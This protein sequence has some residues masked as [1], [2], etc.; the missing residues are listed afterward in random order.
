[1]LHET[2]GYK[3]VYVID[4]MPYQIGTI[5]TKSDKILVYE[6]YLITLLQKLHDLGFFYKALSYTYWFQYK[7]WSLVLVWYKSLGIL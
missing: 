6:E 7:E 1:M 3:S 2:T 4:Y 5:V